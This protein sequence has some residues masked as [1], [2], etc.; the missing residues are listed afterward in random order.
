MEKC[1]KRLEDCPVRYSKLGC[2][3]VNHHIWWPERVYVDAGEI[4]EEFRDLSENQVPMCKGEEI[5]LH[6]STLP[7]SMPSPKVMRHVV[8]TQRLRR[9][10]AVRPIKKP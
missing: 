4:A 10:L 8:E 2:H 7:P 6:E 1:H 5:R 9:E 3:I